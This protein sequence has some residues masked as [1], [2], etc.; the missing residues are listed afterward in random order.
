[1][2]GVTEVHNLRIHKEKESLAFDLLFRHNDWK[3]WGFNRV[4]QEAKVRLPSL[5]PGSEK[6]ARLLQEAV[7]YREKLVPFFQHAPKETKVRHNHVIRCFKQLLSYP[8]S[9]DASR[10]PTD[11]L[12]V[13]IAN[14][15]S[16]LTHNQL[17]E[18]H[19]VDD[20]V[21]NYLVFDV[22]EQLTATI[23]QTWE[24]AK[25]NSLSILTATTGR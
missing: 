5:E 17:E 2:A 19:G 8:Q 24:Q 1:M 13:D 18:P 7:G 23:F 21:Q 10:F 11:D 25:N 20:N 9:C 4:I 3:S 15:A 6:F 22:L 12:R 16:Y 14:T